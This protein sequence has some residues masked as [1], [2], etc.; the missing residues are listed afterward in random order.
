MC[1]RIVGICEHTKKE[2]VMEWDAEY[3]DWLCLH[4]ETPE[5]DADEVIKFR[6]ENYN[7]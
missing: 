3:N 6:M 7:G 5:Q 4:N 2:V 1:H